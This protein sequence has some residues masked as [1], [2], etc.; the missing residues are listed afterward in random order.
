MIL[1][2]LKGLNP[3]RLSTAFPMAHSFSS[4][5]TDGILILSYNRTQLTRFFELSMFQ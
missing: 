5:K 3:A 2:L 4:S 1:F